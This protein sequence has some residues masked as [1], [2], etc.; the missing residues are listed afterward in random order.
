MP[1]QRRQTPRAP[2]VPNVIEQL[3]RDPTDHG[4]RHEAER[5]AR[6]GEQES[7]GQRAAMGVLAVA[8]AALMGWTGV[9]GYLAQQAEASSPDSARARLARELHVRQQVLDDEAA[10]LAKEQDA[11]S[12]RARRALEAG[13]GDGLADRLEANLAAAAGSP[14]EGDGVRITLDD[15]TD[16][17]TPQERVTSGDLQQVTNRLWRSGAEGIAVNGIRLSPTASIRYAGEAL[18]VDF[19]ALRPPYVVEA[20][21][22]DDLHQRF[23]ETGGGEHLEELTRQ[24]RV[25][26]SASGASD[27][28][29]PADTTLTV[30]H[31]R[32]VDL[33]N[34]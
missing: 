9:T 12:S 22:P 34:S 17:E 11:L 10:L 2:R 24:Y 6:T 8:V 28:V 23:E 4:Y 13:G 7:A 14:L 3:L 1:P 21:G 29:L 5:R 33:E 19:R 16:P 25:R 26:T 30:H 20:V 32:P 18:V 31:A 15:P 27:L